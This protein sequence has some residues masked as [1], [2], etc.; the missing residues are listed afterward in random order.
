M[1]KL[2][3]G[4]APGHVRETA[5][6]A[7]EAWLVWN[8]KASEPTVEYEIDYEPQQIPISRALGLVWNCTDVVPGELFAR[9]RE[10]LSEPFT[11]ESALKS[12]SY[13][14]CARAVLGAMRSA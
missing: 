5:G 4:H 13:A 3:S 11:H 7:F 2:R 8:G 14:A 10:E 9:I 1:S 12:R 6:N